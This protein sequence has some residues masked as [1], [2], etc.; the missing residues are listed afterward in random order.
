M[1]E[2]KPYVTVKPFIVAELRA[3]G[4]CIVASAAAGHAHGAGHAAT[5]PRRRRGIA[6]R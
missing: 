1:P 3:E 6:A 4:P 2:V 5:A